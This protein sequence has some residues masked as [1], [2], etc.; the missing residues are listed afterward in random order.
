MVA[1][2]PRSRA[3]R[4]RRD[5]RAP[6]E[7][8]TVLQRVVGGSYAA[9]ESL[10]GAALQYLELHGVPAIPVSTGP[11][12]RPRLGG[13]F[14]LKANPAQKGF[15]DIAAALPPDGRLVLIECK[16]GSASRSAE[17]IAL[18]QRFQS[19]GALC[20][21][22]RNALELAPYVQRSRFQDRRTGG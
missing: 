4:P 13:G 10:Q 12:V 18:Q 17:Q 8:A 15:S 20:V 1:W 5:R 19:A 2:L 7:A 16:T 22:I 3:A 9:H 6:Q 14:D 21:V 11:K